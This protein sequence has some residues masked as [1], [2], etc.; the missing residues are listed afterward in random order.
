MKTITFSSILNASFRGE[1]RDINVLNK[2][3][4][5]VTKRIAMERCLRKGCS[6]IICS[7]QG[8]GEEVGRRRVTLGEN[9]MLAWTR[10][11]ENQKMNIWSFFKKRYSLYLLLNSSEI[12]IEREIQCTGV[13]MALGL[14]L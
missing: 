4:F 11:E 7:P 5:D 10:R 9:Q 12:S 13:P 6:Q 1:R 8:N 14:L 2:S 3:I